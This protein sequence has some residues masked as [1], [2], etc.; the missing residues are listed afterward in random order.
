MMNDKR[1]V[2]VFILLISLYGNLVGQVEKPSWPI[3]KV[4]EESFYAIGTQAYIYSVT[5]FMMYSVL[6]Q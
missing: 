5:P 4:T 1:R 2:A 6:Y 3:D